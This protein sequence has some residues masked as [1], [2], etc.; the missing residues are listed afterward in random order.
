[1]RPS[2]NLENKT[3]LEAWLT[4]LEN[5]HWN[6][7]TTFLTILGVIDMIKFQISSR[8][9]TGKEVPKSSRLE[10][11]EKFLTNNFALSEAEDNTPM[12][13]NRGGTT[14]L[15]LLRTLLAICQKSLNQ[16]SGK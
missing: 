14:D 12:P 2:N 9:E 6:T 8:G 4:V 10:F 11:S 15:L 5:Q 16:V 1:M 13:L 3:H 7:I